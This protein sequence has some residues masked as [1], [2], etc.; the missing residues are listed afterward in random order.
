MN[1]GSNWLNMMFL[2]QSAL[3]EASKEPNLNLPLRVLLG[4]HHLGRPVREALLLGVH[5]IVERA[6]R[7][8]KP[9]LVTPGMNPGIGIS[10][11]VTACCHLAQ[12]VD[13]VPEH[14][15]GG[16]RHGAV[17]PVVD[18]HIVHDVL[19]V[20]LVLL[21]YPVLVGF[22]LR[23]HLLQVYVPFQQEFC[24]PFLLTKTGK[25]FSVC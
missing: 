3:M 20:R 18:D 21:Q 4:A 14:L 22:A 24:S 8:G 12:V 11:A 9:V 10:V 16:V 17:D 25:C 23:Q 13:A 19:H 1:V 6:A 5:N 15:P 2:H 7:L